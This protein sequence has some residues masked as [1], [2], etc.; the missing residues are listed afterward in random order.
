MAYTASIAKETVFG[1][2]RV[3]MYNV[4]A[5]ANSGAIGTGLNYINAVSISLQSASSAGFKVKPNVGSGATAS[6]FGQIFV[7]GC[8]NGDAFQLVVYGQ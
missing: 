4:T 2:Q 8:T 5:D 7:S 3:K 6:Q 1:D